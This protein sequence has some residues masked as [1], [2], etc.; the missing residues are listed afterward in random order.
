MFFGTVR[1]SLRRDEVHMYAFSQRSIDNIKASGIYMI[2]GSV[3]ILIRTKV[4]VYY[5]NIRTRS[6]YT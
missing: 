2:S 4:Y 6:S 3:A 1:F 5:G